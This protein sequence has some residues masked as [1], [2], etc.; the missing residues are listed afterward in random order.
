MNGGRYGLLSNGFDSLKRRL[1]HLGGFVLSHKLFGE[2]GKG[3]DSQ[4]FYRLLECVFGSLLF[5]VG[6]APIIAW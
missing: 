4:R 1:S 2:G 6:H 3:C 5:F